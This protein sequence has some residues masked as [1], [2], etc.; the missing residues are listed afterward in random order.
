MPVV[1]GL[2]ISANTNLRAAINEAGTAAREGCPK[3]AFVLAF[4]THNYPK[5][6]LAQAAQDLAELFPGAQTAGGQVNGITYA[7]ERYD[8]V[9]A[10]R[11]AVA[12]IAFGGDGVRGIVALADNSITDPR[13]M[14]RAL[15]RDALQ[16]L[17]TE[18]V[19]GVFLG[20]GISQIPPVDQTVLDGI[21]DVAPRLRLTGTGF[22]GG[23]QMDGS[24]NPG[25]A[26]LGRTLVEKGVIMAVLGGDVRLGFG[27]ANGMVSTGQGSFVTNAYGPVIAELGGRPAKDVVLDLLTADDPGSREMFEKNP[28]VMGVEKG[29]TLGAPDPEGDFF[30]CHPP[31][32]FTPDGGV[33]DLFSPKMGVGLA[34]TR[35][36]GESCMGAV[37]AAAEMVRQDAASD[38]FEFTLSF[39]CALRG[40]TLGAT[41]AKEDAELRRHVQSRNH[42]G[43]VANGE[44]GCYRHGRPMFTCWIFALMGAAEHADG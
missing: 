22:C 19:G 42:L 1:T 39:S 36:T 4:I 32:A 26:F 8:A 40:F 2:A 15:A 31:A 43:I 29:I 44:I 41:A 3:P 9:F 7:D 16:Q 38:R 33:L 34:V 6:E 30:W 18:P 27:A 25:S 37:E 23:M 24:Y 28:Q 10:N 17:G 14:G 5:A 11:H 13:E 12:V 35:I 21:R 20:I